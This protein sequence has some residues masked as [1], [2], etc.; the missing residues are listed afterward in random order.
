[1]EMNY[2]LDADNSKTYPVLF[3]EFIEKIKK[4]FPKNNISEIKDNIIEI[5]PEIV[6]EFCKYKVI[7]YH[8]TR[9]KSISTF[10]KYGI[11]IPNKS[12]TLQTILKKES[13]GL[14]IK[15]LNCEVLQRRGNTI[16]FVPSYKYA[17]NECGLI[18]FLKNVGGEILTEF[19]ADKKS[20]SV[21]KAYIIKFVVDFKKI[22][23]KNN[24]INKMIIYY[25]FDISMYFESFIYDEVPPYDILEYIEA[26][27]ILEKLEGMVKNV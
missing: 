27:K 3:L 26:D 15:M 18:P 20:L 8:F 16:H 23:D 1:M 25:L 5:P 19:D 11:L 10:L 13:N 7:C 14:D 21:G 6:N 4:S 17:I 22:F 2:L 24:F 9:A 12:K